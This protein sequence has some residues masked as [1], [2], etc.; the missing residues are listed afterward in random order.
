MKVFKSTYIHL[1]LRWQLHGV[2]S[3]AWKMS[4]YGVFSGP[5]FCAF[6]LNTDAVFAMKYSSLSYFKN[7]PSAATHI[8]TSHL[9]WSANK[10]TGFYME[11]NTGLTWINQLVSSPSQVVL[12]K[13]NLDPILSIKISINLS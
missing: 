3:T 11:C 9:I 1:N 4:K 12:Q 5:Y 8:E 13:E 7:H 2:F 6:G 10:M